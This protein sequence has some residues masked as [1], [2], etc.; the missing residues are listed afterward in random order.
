M[1]GGSGGGAPGG[2]QGAGRRGRE[3]A[4]RAARAIRADLRLAEAQRPAPASPPRPKDLLAEIK[5]RIRKKGLKPYEVR[6]LFNGADWEVLAGKRPLSVAMMWG[7]SRALDI[8]IERLVAS[9]AP[10]PAKHERTR[11]PSVPVGQ[12]VADDR[13]TCLECGARRVYLTRHIGAAHGLDELTYRWRWGLTLDHPLTAPGFSARCRRRA[14]RQGLGGDTSRF[15]RAAGSAPA[16]EARGGEAGALDQRAEL[17]PDDLGLDRAVAGE[18]LEAAID[19]RDHPLAP[20]DV[21]VG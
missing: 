9:R 7:V 1:R 21:G 15:R 20:H 19:A 4:G 10:K 6:R 16:P 3:V 14:K 2:A 13:V 18:G 5:A 17:A 12:S 11:P 8:P